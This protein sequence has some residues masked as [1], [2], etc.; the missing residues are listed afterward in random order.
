MRYISIF[1]FNL[2]IWG[3]S[4]GVFAQT[5][6]TIVT[7]AGGGLE[8]GDNILAT[9]VVLNRPLGIALDTQGNLYIA[10]T[11]NHRIRRVDVLTGIITTVAGTGEPG[12]S[13]DGGP[14]T[15]ALLN[16]PNAIAVDS[17]GNI[18]I[19]SGG[20]SEGD[21]HNR[22]IRRIDAFGIITTVAGTGEGGFNDLVVPALQATFHEIVALTMLGDIALL[23]SDSLDEN[24]QGNNRVRQFNLANNTIGTIAGNGSAQASNSQDG[25]QATRAGLTPG[26]L[27]VTGQ[28]DLLIADFNNGRIRRVSRAMQDTI[29]VAVINTVAGRGATPAEELSKDLYKGDGGVAT[30]ALFFS[31]LGVAVDESGNIYIG[32]TGNNRIRVVEAETSNVLTIAGTGIEGA[33]SEGTLCLLSDLGQPTHLLIDGNGD[34]IFIDAFNNRIRKLRDPAFRMPLFNAI[35]TDIDFGRISVGD[36]A[37]SSLRVENRGNLSVSIETAIS[38]NPGF[39]VLSELPF[40]VGVVQT[41]EIEIAF[42]PV[43]TGVAEGVITITTNDP[44][45]PS[46]A[47]NVQGWGDAAN[48]GI[49]PSDVLIFDRTSI[50][51]SQTLPVRIS[52]LGAGVLVV[53]NAT[54]TDSQFVVE[55]TDVLRIESGQ[56]QRLPIIFRP[57]SEDLQQAVLTI[58]SN[59]PGTPT[60]RLQLQGIGQS[61]QSGGFVNVAHNTGLGDTGAGF[62]AAWADFDNDNDPDLYLVRSRE[63]NRLYRNDG[64]GF[65]DIA[66]EMGV[67]DSG[68]GSAG[69]WGDVDGDGDL[70]LYVTNFGESNRLY[71]NDGAGF[72]DIAATFGVDDSGDGYGAAW[73]DYD[74]DGDLDLYVA[75]FGANRFYQNN[76]NGFS[77]R[78]DSLGIG[79]IESGIQP[80]WGDF[81]NDGDPDLFLANSGPNRLFRNDGEQFTSVENVFSPVDTGPS[82]GAT[83]GDFDNDGDLDLFIPYFGAANRFYTNE[84]NG[85]FRDRAPEM[86]LNHDGRGRGAVWGDFDND[87]DLD[88]YVTNSGQPNLYY[89]NEDGRFIEMSD[90]LGVALNADSRGV[91]LADYDNDGKLDFYVAVQDSSDTLF[92]NLEADG[93]WIAIRLRGTESS[94]DAIGTRLKIEFKDGNGN[95]RHAIREITGGASFLSQDALLPTFG[96]GKTEK[97]EVLSLRWPSGIVQQFRSDRDDLSVNRVI[98]ITE[99][100]PL[101]PARV[102]LFSDAN[103]LLAN[104]ISEIE[105]TA[106]IVTIDNRPLPTSDQAVKFRIESGSG[107]IISSEKSEPVGGDSVAVRDGVAYARFRSGQD[108]GRVVI[109]AESAGLESGRAEIELIKPFSEDA[110][111]IRTVAGS[112]DES[113]AFQGDGGAAIEARLQRPQGVLVDSSGNIYIADTENHRIRFV[114]VATNIIQTIAGSGY[115]EDLAAPRGLVFQGDLLISQM[116]NHV[117]STVQDEVLFAFAGIGVG[118][119]GG[120]GGRALNANL[121]SPAGLAVDQSG[122]IYIADTEN[123]RIRKVDSRG[124]ITTVVGSGD[125]DQGAFLGDGGAGTQAR[126]NRP[127]AIA[128]DQS[129]NIYIADTENHRIRKVDSRGIITTVVGT[130]Q[131][132][133]S[134]DGGAGTQAQLNFPQGIAVDARGYLFIA[135]TENHRIRLLDL[136]SGL[137]QTVAGTGLGQFD[138]EEG[139]ALAISLNAPHG[140]DLSPTGTLL[141]ADTANH[142]IRELSVLFDL[143]LAPPAVPRAKSFD[144]NADGRFDFN[145]FLIFVNAFDSADTRFDLNADGRV[146]FGDFLYFARVYELRIKN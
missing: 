121:R 108:Q 128:I 86:M 89:Q 139:G 78:S 63:P 96:V 32:D 27:A 64:V 68:D 18:Y 39:R 72:T 95:N 132:E 125:P 104:G 67:D 136:N 85:A 20:A 93:N 5:R 11:D 135:D 43:Q 54:T 94:T 55:Q 3:L 2:L 35:S 44:R 144:F 118:Q 130:G 69:I 107:L 49:F 7:I 88:L 98:D 40:E 113:D 115:A 62:G 53:P 12:F 51:Q 45:T 111:T 100:P 116:G 140:L 52:N 109:V 16:T 8:D 127:S 90:S 34:L 42:D 137:I 77:E 38:D 79:D 28:G 101:P 97:I 82:F 14:A 29:V 110:L 91:A 105:L 15:S 134:G 138:G 129:G 122:N 47:V 61:A 74:R 124:I 80:T 133:F 25:R 26:Q 143:A 36:P 146:G 76:G 50:G 92:R 9:D 56:S 75:N 58:F 112:G 99:Q 145:D 60:V 59:A 41:A 117:V 30:R 65:T 31:P 123:H 120:D 23:I 4:T 103:N 142:R 37:V 10:D 126:L 24:G 106:Q 131:N 102:L 19:S 1:F 6:G 119:F 13:G 73:A 33:G 81:D 71:R 84:G 87:G 21:V 46:V 70:D 66:S 22:R 141:I 17:A 48:I 83:W 57:Q 114:S